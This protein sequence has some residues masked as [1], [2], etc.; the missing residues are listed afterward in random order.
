MLASPT[1]STKSLS[2]FRRGNPLIC[3]HHREGEMVGWEN[4]LEGCFQAG[5][6]E[7]FAV[8]EVSEDRRFETGLGVERKW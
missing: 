1:I 3:A 8:S 5:T 4:A 6:R 7:T 2:D